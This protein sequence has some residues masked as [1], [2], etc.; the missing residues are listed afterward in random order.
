M[1]GSGRLGRR[2]S[3]S[4]GSR[5]CPAGKSMEQFLDRKTGVDQGMVIPWNVDK[6]SRTR[7]RLL[8]HDENDC[9]RRSSTIAN[10]YSGLAAASSARPSSRQL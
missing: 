10:T 1:G 3:V 2:M 5:E 7:R 8:V 4:S 9:A 6:L